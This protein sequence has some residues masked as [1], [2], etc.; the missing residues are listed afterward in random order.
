MKAF[1]IRTGIFAGLLL[2]LL[3]FIKNSVPYS[4]GNSRMFQ[5]IEHLSA[6][7]TNYDCLFF[8]SSITFR[9][10]NP[11]LFDSLTN[12]KSYNMGTPGTNFLETH[13]L[14]EHFLKHY[15]RSQNIQIF[16]V[17]KTPK[18]IQNHEFQRVKEK[19]YFDFKRLKLGLRK[20]WKKENSYN[21]RQIYRHLISYIE[22]QLCIG[23][24]RGIKNFHLGNVKKLPEPVLENQQGFISLEQEVKLTQKEI[25]LKRN[26]RYLNSKAVKQNKPVSNQ[27]KTMVIEQLSPKKLNI[28]T[29]CKQVEFY[30][31]N[32]I[33]LEVEY[34]FDRTHFNERGVEIFTKKLAEAATKILS[35]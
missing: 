24:L 11:M 23:E 34:H 14:I 8:G 6:D 9:H 31:I 10:I 35:D 21:S 28:N 7:S 4:W 27:E 22:N 32:P 15:D 30:Y 20:F 1:I 33:E 26:Q 2:A 18:P 25:L 17:S 13:F 29:Y 5:K 16:L 12:L 19:Y 3:F